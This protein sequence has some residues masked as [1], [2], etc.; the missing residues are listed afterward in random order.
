MARGMAM[1]EMS[2]EDY[3]AMNHVRKQ[4]WANGIYGYFVGS[5]SCVVA[6]TIVS[7]VKKH[8]YPQIPVALNRN[9]LMASFFLGGTLG[10]F[11]MSLVAGTNEVHHMH[12]IFPKGA[13]PPPKSYEQ[14]REEA[15]IA[16]WKKEEPVREPK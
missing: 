14:V 11:I 5:S 9:T 12:D 10:S 8:V 1:E 16:A 2:K 15:T 3:M 4:L 13:N 6:H 7:A